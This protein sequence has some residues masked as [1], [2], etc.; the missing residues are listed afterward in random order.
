MSNSTP[1]VRIGDHER[2]EAAE[3]LSAH[4][5][6]GRLGIDELEQRLERV[7]AAVFARDLDALE[8]DLPAPA[9]ARPREWR[10]PRAL[11]A[12]LLVAAA[13]TVAVG[14]PVV[15]LFLL[16]VLLW[17]RGPHFAPV[18]RLR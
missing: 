4:A 15:P 5:A 11:L 7:D 1:S 8:V 10:P 16:A 18:R 12:C 14:H 3:R 6:A 17:R 9:R 13:A 2:S